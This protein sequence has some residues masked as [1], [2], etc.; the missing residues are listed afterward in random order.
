MS[1]LKLVDETEAHVAPPPVTKYKLFEHRSLLRKLRVELGSV[2][3]VDNIEE[4]DGIRL[5]CGFACLVRQSRR[6]LDDVE[7]ATK[8]MYLW[9]AGD[10]SETN[11]RLAKDLLKRKVF[12]DDTWR[13][14]GSLFSTN[15][16]D[17][18]NRN[19]SVPLS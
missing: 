13:L 16:H 14:H 9:M 2:K 7:T 6:G 19:R 11:E 15:G 1:S 8:H 12:S 5:V 3:D 4:G 17:M 10:G 18:I